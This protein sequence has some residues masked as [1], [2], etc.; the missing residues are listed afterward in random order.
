MYSL[1]YVQIYPT[2]CCFTIPCVAC[3]LWRKII[4]P[5]DVSYV[6]F[7]CLFIKKSTDNRTIAGK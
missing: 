2:L 4:Y 3:A 7:F 5:K 6:D 1:I